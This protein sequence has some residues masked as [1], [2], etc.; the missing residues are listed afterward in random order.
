[1]HDAFIDESMIQD[2][3]A[4]VDSSFSKQLADAMDLAAAG[5]VQPA[6]EAML[7]PLHTIKGTAGF[8]GMA[9]AS[10][11]THALE[12]YLKAVQSGA[13]APDTALMN[14]GVDMVFTLLERS[15]HGEELASAGHEALALQLRGGP[16]DGKKE[17]PAQGVTVENCGDV[18]VIRVRL[19]RVHLPKQYGPIIE[20]LETMPG[21]RRTLLDLEGVRTLNST[22][23][24]AVRV[25]ADR[26]HIS[27]CGLSQACQATFY[28][29]GFNEVMQAYATEAD[30]WEG[31]PAP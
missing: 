25:A 18:A 20:A 11:F 26:L 16:A 5:E 19:A 15:R 3:F 13:A 9:E 14:K 12:D 23:W 31:R 24:G 22:T 6:V 30:F 7:R 10:S 21:D 27:V 28:S 2:F 17:G 8:L 1:M 29:W 4:D